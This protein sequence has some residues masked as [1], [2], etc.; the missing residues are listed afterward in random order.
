MN[1][2][3]K[4]LI[5]MALATLTGFVYLAQ[6]QPA[7]EISG[8]QAS[9]DPLKNLK[10]AM[11]GDLDPGM[12][13]TLNPE[14]T[15][16]Y[17]EGGKQVKGNEFMEAMMSG[18]Y[19]PEPYINDNK[20]IK[21]FV[22]RA[23]T[24]E[25]KKQI[26]SMFASEDDK[27]PVGKKAKPFAVTDMNGKKYSLEKLKGKIIVINFWSIQCKY[28]RI[29]MPEL[30]KLVDEYK[31]KKVVFLGLATNNNEQLK[32]FLEKTQFKYIIVPDSGGVAGIYGVA[33]LPT[34]MVIGKDSTVTYFSTGFG[35]GSVNKLKSEID[36]LLAE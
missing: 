24:E 2:A 17:T 5:V 30:N 23:A 4:L 13:I 19:V 36:K 20:E 3:V 34:H 14:A 6:E 9:E 1:F 18:N 33:G 31:K 29:E 10:K 21:A 7:G 25:E 15:P 12:Q 22:L 16:V 27:G 35:P 8:R 26:L 28:C 32:S 11:P